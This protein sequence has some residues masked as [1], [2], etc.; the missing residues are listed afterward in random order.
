ML[1]LIAI[2]LREKHLSQIEELVSDTLQ[3]KVTV[4]FCGLWQIRE[5]AYIW[6]YHT[7]VRYV[8]V[9]YY[10][11]LSPLQISQKGGHFLTLRNL[12][13]AIFSED[14]SHRHTRRHCRDILLLT[15][16]RLKLLVAFIYYSACMLVLGYWPCPLYQM[17]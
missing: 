1:L 2:H 15:T 13:L 14:V 6:R 9:H 12:F 17:Q 4:S 16:L 3:M 10:I 7:T 5:V 11:I 8:G